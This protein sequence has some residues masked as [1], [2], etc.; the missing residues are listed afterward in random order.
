MFLQTA[1]APTTAI[2]SY[3]NP[4][5]LR[6]HTHRK[7]LLTMWNFVIGAI[8]A[9]VVVFASTVVAIYLKIKKISIFDNIK[10]LSSPLHLNFVFVKSDKVFVTS[11]FKFLFLIS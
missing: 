3:L 7:Q 9:S 10:G 4:V 2:P 11:Q 6:R 8:I 1:V 5:T